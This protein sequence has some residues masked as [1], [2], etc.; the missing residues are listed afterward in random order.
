MLEI[1]CFILNR[2]STAQRQ[3]TV[4]IGNQA[5]KKFLNIEYLKIFILYFEEN[6]LP[7]Q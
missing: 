5:G 6:L 1:K 7:Y 3:T 4:A 2:L